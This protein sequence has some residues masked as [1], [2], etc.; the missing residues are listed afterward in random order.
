MCRSLLLR[1]RCSISIPEAEV[2]YMKHTFVR[3]D[4]AIDTGAAESESNDRRESQKFRVRHVDG[5]ID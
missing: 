4:K 1:L 3:L 2:R 5:L